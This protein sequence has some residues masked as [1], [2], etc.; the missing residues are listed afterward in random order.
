MFTTSTMLIT[1]CTLLPQR[2]DFRAAGSVEHDSVRLRGHHDSCLG[3]VRARRALHDASGDSSHLGCYHHQYTFGRL[4]QLVRALPRQGRGHWFEPS[5]AY[6]MERDITGHHLIQAFGGSA[7]EKCQ[8]GFIWALACNP[9]NEEGVHSE[10]TIDWLTWLKVT[11]DE[12]LSILAQEVLAQNKEKIKQ[13]KKR[14]R[15]TS[16]FALSL[17]DPQTEARRLWK[18]LALNPYRDRGTPHGRHRVR[19]VVKPRRRKRTR[20]R[21]QLPRRPR[22]E[23]GSP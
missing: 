5:N 6:D 2:H 16:E 18:D 12:V 11:E 13:A 3:P 17:P 21:V 19:L 9:L 1:S 7:I 10:V 20:R 23:P 8:R 15:L 14:G 22:S 4:A